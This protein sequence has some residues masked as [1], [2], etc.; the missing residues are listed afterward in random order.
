MPPPE[1]G[2]WAADSVPS[3]LNFCTP[4]AFGCFASLFFH[5]TTAGGG[6]GGH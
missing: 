5:L 2:Q 3:D 6:G 1:L 4:I